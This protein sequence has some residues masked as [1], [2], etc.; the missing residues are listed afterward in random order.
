MKLRC[1]LVNNKGR[2]LFCS[3]GSDEVVYINEIK[4]KSLI[5]GGDKES[6]RAG[7]AI[8]TSGT[9]Y[10]ITGDQDYI[11]SS[12]KFV[13]AIDSLSDTLEAFETISN[14]HQ[15][16]LNINTSRLLHNLTTLNA[17]NIQEIYSLVPQEILS[18]VPASKQISVVEKVVIDDPRDT[19]FALLRIAKNNAAMKTEFSVF[20]K[21]FDPNPRLEKKSHNVHKVLMNVLYLFFPDFTDKHVLV[22][23]DCPENTIAYF[24]YESIHV[25]MYHL[26]ENAV[27]Y[28]QP[29]SNF[30][31][32]I[33]PLNEVVI[34]L[35]E[36]TSLAI[37]EEERLN[38]FEEGYSGVI[39]KKIGKSGSGI[40]M[41]RAKAILGINGASISLEICPQTFHEYNGIPYQ[42]NIFKI[43]L[44]SNK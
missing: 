25:A 33:T 22:T 14:D 7:L 11:K 31:I 44:K 32:K 26:I 24:D 6:L 13:A 37:S 8:N 40:G 43:S 1:R 18:K 30:N 19:A 38:I 39:A 12:K 35:F 5:F 27:K 4:K 34:L 23:L 29:H 20:N 42:N 41:T 16:K 2:V 15:E 10:A 17:H 36:M 28:V 9:V 21:L 3:F